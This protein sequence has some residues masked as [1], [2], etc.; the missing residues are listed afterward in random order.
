MV[1]RA[2]RLI[3]TDPQVTDVDGCSGY[4]TTV[5]KA[6]STVWTNEAFAGTY[7]TAVRAPGSTQASL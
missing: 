2:I 3:P 7:G 5:V 4:F 1:A 6:G